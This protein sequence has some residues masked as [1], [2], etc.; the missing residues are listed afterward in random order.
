M[1]ADADPIPDQ[2]SDL[3]AAVVLHAPSRTVTMRIFVDQGLAEVLVTAPNAS[4]DAGWV[5][6]SRPNPAK[7]EPGPEA[8]VMGD[9]VLSRSP[10]SEKQSLLS[11]R[12]GA[13]T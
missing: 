8:I 2:V 11:I 6:L 7:G 12:R 4:V 9:L 3:L 1:P 13:G 5:N 10:T